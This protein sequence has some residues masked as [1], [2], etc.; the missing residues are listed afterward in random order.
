MYLEF[1]TFSTVILVRDEKFF[2]L[3]SKFH[4]LN[5][6]HYESYCII[7]CSLYCLLTLIFFFFLQGYIDILFLCVVNKSR[8]KQD[9]FHFFVHY[10]NIVFVVMLLNKSLFLFLYLMRLQFFFTNFDKVQ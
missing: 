1:D 9:F 4:F 6:L 8:V 2:P 7:F 10:S 3:R 5:N